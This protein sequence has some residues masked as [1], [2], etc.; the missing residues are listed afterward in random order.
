VLRLEGFFPLPH[1]LSLIYLFGRSYLRITGSPTLNSTYTLAPAAADTRFP[2]ANVAP[3][4]M[5][6]P[7]RDIY[8]IGVSVDLLSVIA[9]IIKP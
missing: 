5:P 8:S 3:P 1:K 4:T 6:A 2:A 9:K 7:N